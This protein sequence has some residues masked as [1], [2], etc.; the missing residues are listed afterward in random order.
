MAPALEVAYRTSDSPFG[1]VLAIATGRGI[2]RVA[3]EDEDEEAALDE[4]GS[5]LGVRP[6]RG[7]AS[8]D[9]FAR[10][11]DEYFAGRRRSFTPA[12]DLS[13]TG[14]F[15]R[16]VL[17]ATALV[18]YGKVATYG[19]VAAM[20]GSP[21]AARA[22]GNALRGNPVPILVPCHRIVPAAGGIGGYSGKESLKAALLA[23]E[24]ES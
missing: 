22:A 8:L 14:G 18:P 17:E 1:R 20:A 3:Y 7:A 12:A 23:I 10:E 11:L 15:P 21:R 13:L 2:V 16:R 19:R 6:A 24:D 9:A 5:A 4:V